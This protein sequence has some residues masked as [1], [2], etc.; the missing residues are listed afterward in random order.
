MKRELFDHTY[1]SLFTELEDLGKEIPPKKTVNRLR[2]DQQDDLRLF[3]VSFAQLMEQEGFS[4]S[5]V[6]AG[7]LHM[8]FLGHEWTIRQERQQRG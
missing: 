5:G 8:F 4:V 3:F 1:T 2:K 6:A 7:L